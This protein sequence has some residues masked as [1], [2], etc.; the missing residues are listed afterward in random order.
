MSF[1]TISANLNTLINTPKIGK[2]HGQ[3]LATKR[4]N[5]LTNLLNECE[6]GTSAVDK[7]SHDLFADAEDKF[8]KNQEEL[9]V[10]TL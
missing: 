9:A 5:L 8:N 10:V 7:Y 4:Y 6:A 1:T 2:R 3:F